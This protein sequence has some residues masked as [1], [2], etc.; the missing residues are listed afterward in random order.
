MATTSKKTTATPAASATRSKKP[1]AK[2]VVAATPA[3]KATAP[4]TAA[5]PVKK[6]VAVATKKA[7]AT[8]AKKT[9]K[10]ASKQAVA[11]K[12]APSK[13]VKKITFTPEERYRWIETAA[14]YRAEQRGFATGHETEDWK[15]SEAQFDAMLKA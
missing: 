3:S 12:S 10:P 11:E 9:E 7:A 4:K 13:S 1:V 5:T 14:Y 15:A 8:P 2:K 6:T